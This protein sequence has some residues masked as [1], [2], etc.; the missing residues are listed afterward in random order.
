MTNKKL[1]NKVIAAVFS[2]AL[3]AT[4][5]VCPVSSAGERKAFAEENKVYFSAE[6]FD[7]NSAGLI[8]ADI[9]AEGTAGQKVTVSYHTESATAIDGIDY[10]GV[11]NV[12]E[13]TIG[14][15]G[16]GKYTIAI[17]AKGGYED[18]QIINI[19][20]NSEVYG[21]YYSLV[22]DKAKNA[23]IT[24][25]ICKCYLPYDNI[26][27]GTVGVKQSTGE[28]GYINDYMKMQYIYNGGDGG[29]DGKDTWKSWK[30]GVSFNNDTTRKWLN[31]Y[32]NTGLA[33]AYSSYLIKQIGVSK[34]I[35]STDIYVLAGND[36]FR[37]EYS[38]VQHNVP[39]CYLYLGVE[40]QWS[41]WSGAEA[42][43]LNGRAM[44]LIAN[45]KNPYKEDDDYVDVNSADVSPDNRHVYWIQ[46]R[47]AWYA[48]KNALTDSVFYKTEPYNGTLDMA[49]IVWNKNKEVDIMA[50]NIW[51]LM[52]LIDETC[53]T[54]VGQYVDDSRI[55]VDGKLR[56]CIRFSEPV[57]A[58]KKKSIEVKF[59]SSA[60]PY[61]ADYVEG[62]YTDTLVYELEP[63]KINIYSANYQ[64]PTDD[65]GDLAYN[66]DAYK[67]IRNN[68]VQ[69]TDKTRTLT[70]INGSINNVNPR[71]AIDK[72][73]N[74]TYKNNHSLMLSINDNGNVDIT[75][76]TVYYEWSKEET[77][78]N[79]YDTLSYKY[80]RSLYDEDMGSVNVTLVKNEDEGI[81]SGKYYLHALAVGRYGLTDTATYGPYFLDGDPPVV[82]QEPLPQNELKTKTY[83]FTNSKVGG[84]EIVN[85]S[86][87]AKVKGENDAVVH[88]LPL[89]TD[90]VPIKGFKFDGETSSYTYFSNINDVDT[91]GDGLPDDD[92]DEFILSL[93][94][95]NPRM[96]VS[97]CFEVEDSAGNQAETNR[98]TVVYDK[99]DTFKVTS[100][101]P[102]DKGYAQITDIQTIYPAY[103]ISSVVRGDGVGIAVSISSIDRT[104]IVD[105]TH[106][107]VF[108]GEKEYAAS[109]QDPYTV[110]IGDLTSGFYQ[111]VPNIYGFVE[112]AEVDLVANPVQ[113]YLTDGKK[114]VTVNK[115]RSEGNLVL[116]GSVFRIDEARYYYLDGEEKVMGH[117][118]GAT[119]NEDQMKYEGGSS[120][121]AFSNVNEAKKYVRYMEYLDLRKRY[122]HQNHKE[123]IAQFRSHANRTRK[124][125][126]G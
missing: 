104:Q 9:I 83:K 112:D 89:M 66:L 34:F 60:T 49:M 52:T 74:T 111:L 42:E 22:I 13:I 114:D 116:S 12:A 87:N 33:S 119:Y 1:L 47:D 126:F 73:S 21:R 63:P 19:K 125:D 15:S 102:S 79:K 10:N 28:T 107:R 85:V 64:L 23:N 32:I 121:P 71:L 41:F 16:M 80:S 110:I 43:K 56:F 5:L 44:Y 57:V 124:Q 68:K 18:R 67:I 69:N 105:G 20:A 6:R 97:V 95:D 61:Y 8:Y 75:R 45:G 78:N 90:G 91:D 7:A 122:F 86:L 77:R 120:Y 94:K 4:L 53:P 39:G 58:S 108:L 40:P 35:S 88:R 115:V 59:N 11:N 38:K 103:D 76:G 123:K 70:M 3:F 50:K 29:I 84:A 2:L 72:E 82:T 96:T 48:N 100:S 36:R 25:A 109:E 118:Y 24:M 17:A 65:I 92:L 106:F 37:K 27:D 30:N 31:T 117:L 93:M 101:F 113:F 55:A 51:F 62:N 46:D 26:V 98:V 81:D 99:R 14:E 54:V